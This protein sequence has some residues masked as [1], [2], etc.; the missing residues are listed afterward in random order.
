MAQLNP[1]GSNP[2]VALLTDE[3]WRLVW[4]DTVS[5]NRTPDA[6]AGETRAWTDATSGNSGKLTLTRV[7]QS[8][9]TTC[10]AVRYAISFPGKPVPQEYNLDWCRTA[11]GQWKITPRNE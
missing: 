9:G 1:F 8:N 4:E 3:D 2:N 5:L 7:Y 11:A 6:A 10:H